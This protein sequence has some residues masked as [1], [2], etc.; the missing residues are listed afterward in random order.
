MQDNRKIK[1][2]MAS[3]L[4]AEAVADAFYG[5]DIFRAARVFLDFFADAADHRHDVVV[6]IHIGLFPDFF[7]EPL[8]GQ[9]LSLMFRE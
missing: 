6:V 7:I 2:I 4:L 1:G 3:Y 9:D 5:L 8:L